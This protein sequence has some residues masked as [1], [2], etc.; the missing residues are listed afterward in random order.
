MTATDDSDRLIRA[1]LVEGRTELP[2]EAYV[3]VRSRI[4]RARQGRWTGVRMQLPAA[5]FGR[6][7]AVAAVAVVALLVGSLLPGGLNR[8]V[9]GPAATASQPA[10]GQPLTPGPT[11]HEILGL[12]FPP[13][14]SGEVEPG[15]L[16]L[17]LEGNLTLP[18]RQVRLFAD[19]RLIWD[20]MHVTP[21]SGPSSGFY[22]QRLSP[23]GV[24]FLRSAVLATG[25]FEHDLA[26]ARPTDAPFL[27]IQVRNSGQLVR[28]TWAVR[29]N[30]LIGPDTPV[31]TTAQAEALTKLNL[32]LTNEDDW[33]ASAWADREIT[34]Y[35][36][37]G[38][39]ICFRP[40]NPDNPG[41]APT[42]GLDR[43]LG[44]L[45]ASAVEILRGAP[46]N[47]QSG[48]PSQGGCFEVTTAD[49]YAVAE[50]LE[51]AGIARFKP[52]RSWVFYKLDDPDVSGQEIWITFGAI[53]PDGQANYTGPG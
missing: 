44:W 23:S 50:A 26:L 15:V 19:G 12:P 2:N 8:G 17:S 24:E 49:A 46:V 53:G 14:T 6:F 33:P 32:L 52:N 48:M 13:P 29:E 40:F 30:Y 51:G 11:H 4:D 18:G 5:A 3:V 35:A 16:V 34:P 21:P 28:L 38:Y 47:P 27:S 22:Q 37:S 31:A 36:P 41:V 20:H 7:A 10:S 1:F 45:P 39:A 9:G 25:L 42:P 43:M